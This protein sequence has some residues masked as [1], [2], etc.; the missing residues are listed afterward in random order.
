MRTYDDNYPTCLETFAT[1][2][3]YHVEC[4]PEVVTAA[5]GIEPSESQM[6]GMNMV[7]G[8]EVRRPLSGW[9]LRSRTKVESKDVR[10]H[11]DWIL[12]QIREL[13]SNI[14]SLRVE[15][16]RADIN[17]CWVSVGHGGPML[18]PPQMADLALLNL[19]CGFNLYQSEDSE[20]IVPHQPA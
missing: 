3:F 5:L 19:T 15:G 20:Q 13:G 4:S 7:N 11:I 18:D 16:W 14:Q 6:K 8:R 10:R 12:D 17:C 9:F 1:L 2:R